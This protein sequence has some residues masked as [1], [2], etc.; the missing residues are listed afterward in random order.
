MRTILVTGGI[1]SGKSEVCAHLQ[2]KGYPVYDC[3][4]RT[5]GLYATVPG[6]PH[7]LEYGHAKRG[8]GRVPGRAHIKPVED[9]ITK[10]FERKVRAIII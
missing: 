5:K 10:D 9:K 4:S 8:G 7:L 3:D 2:A 6:L 1:A